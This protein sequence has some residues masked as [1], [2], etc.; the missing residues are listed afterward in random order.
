MTSQEATLC[1]AGVSFGL[2]LLFGIIG[3]AGDENKNKQ[4]EDIGLGG[5]GIFAMLSFVS[6]LKWFLALFIN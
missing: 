1:V 4:V 2:A 3:A 5:M 6:L